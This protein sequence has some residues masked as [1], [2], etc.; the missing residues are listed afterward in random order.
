MH[1]ICVMWILLDWFQLLLGGDFLMELRDKVTILS[2]LPVREFL[3]P[4]ATGKERI[5]LKSMLI[6]LQTKR[7]K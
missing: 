3:I 4:V 1:M 7:V 2:S 6:N 5:K